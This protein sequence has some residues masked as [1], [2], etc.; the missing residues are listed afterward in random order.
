MAIAKPTPAEV[1]RRLGLTVLTVVQEQAIVDE[2]AD[3][4]ADLEAYLSRPLIP[5]AVFEVGQYPT[6]GWPLEDAR[7]WKHLATKHDDRISVVG[8]PT[9]NI[10]GTFDV[11]LL[12]G[13]DGASEEPI[14]RYLRAHAV[15]LIRQNPDIPVGR[16]RVSSVSGD[17]QSVSYSDGGNI[18]AG[19]VGAQPRREDLSRYKRLAVFRRKTHPAPVWP[20]SYGS[21]VLR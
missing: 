18:K 15:E 17:G 21:G 7:A 20:Y 1:G 2:I 14:V 11:N 9:A 3:A 5:T 19:E 10:D 8:V 4:V 13:L 12:V 16:R 6:L